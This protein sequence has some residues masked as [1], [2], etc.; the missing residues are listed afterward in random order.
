[1]VVRTHDIAVTKVKAPF[2]ARAGQTR[3]V[4]ATV[5]GKFYLETVQIDLYKVTSQGEIW[6]ASRTVIVKPS[7]QYPAKQVSFKYTFLPEDVLEGKIKFKAYATI[8]GA[9][10]ALPETNWNISNPVTVNP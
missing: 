3:P 1:V 5:R 7:P 6:I 4:T 10:D 8:A 9:R 2:A